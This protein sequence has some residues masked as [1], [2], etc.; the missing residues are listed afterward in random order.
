MGYYN[1]LGMDKE[2]FSTS[3]DPLFFYGSQEHRA[4]LTR[5]MIEIRLRRGLSVIL[6]DVG[7]GKTTLCRKLLQMFRERENLE[8]Y[9]ILDPTFNNEEL[10]QH[11]HRKKRA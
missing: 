1:L 11:I 2:P 9:I 6:G 5:I 3:P 8:F 4:A 10:F 7:T